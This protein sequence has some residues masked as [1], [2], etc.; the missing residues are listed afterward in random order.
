LEKEAAS[1]Q[2]DNRFLGGFR[3]FITSGTILNDTTIGRYPMGR[4]EGASHKIEVEMYRQLAAI[5]DSSGGYKGLRIH[6]LPGLHDFTAERAFTY[7][8][9][10]SNILDLAA[11]TGAMS[12]RLRD[13]GFNVT[14]TDYVSENFRLHDSIPFF[15]ANLNNNFSRDIECGFDGIMASEIIEHLENPRHFARECF[16]SLKCGGKLILSTPNVDNFASLVSFMRTGTF[17]WFGEHEYE[18]DGHITPITQWQA[19]KCFEEAGFSTLWTGSFGDRFGR[20]RGSPRMLALS[21]LFSLVGRIPR[22]MGNQIFVAVFEKP[23][24]AL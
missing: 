16:K 23:H 17:Q 20:L 4:T 19:K 12:L 2:I 9:P 7:F 13:G 3:L 21:R 24:E 10:G 22:N 15:E 11:G 5:E 14:A 1:A 6:A 8:E 18:R